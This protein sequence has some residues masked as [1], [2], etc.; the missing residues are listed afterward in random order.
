M[1][2]NPSISKITLPSG[3]TYDI[4]DTT[5]RQS[6]ENFKNAT[7]SALHW[8]GKTTTALADHSEVKTIKIGESDYTAKA[9]DVATYT[10]KGSRELEFVFNGTEW[11]EFGSTGS[12]GA[13]AFKDSA[14][15]SVKASGSV[16]KPTFTGKQATIKTSLTV[17]DIAGIIDFGKS[18]GSPVSEEE[19]NYTPSGT[20]EGTEFTGSSTPVNVSGTPTGTVGISTGTGATNYTPAGS[21]S[22][23]P[24]VTMNTTS[25]KPFGSAGSL[26]TLTTSVEN[27]TL[28]ISFSQG[29]LPTAGSAVTVATGVKSASATGSF[30]GT[31]VHLSGSFKGNA[32]TSTGSCTPRGSVSNGIFN[33]TGVYLLVDVAEKTVE[34]TATYTPQ[35]EVS[36][37]TFNG[38]TSNVTVK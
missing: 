16:S 20:I 4:K 32:M 5:A 14:T 12:L 21:I 11:Q 27:E 8:V 36:Q 34:G 15:G 7:S 13:L 26:P 24:T 33:G 25:V 1:A 28:K 17:P 3:T 2:N 18:Q 38:G 31:G 6:I 10:P 22:V 35:G 9:G 19:V 30:S 23:K 29:S 37:P